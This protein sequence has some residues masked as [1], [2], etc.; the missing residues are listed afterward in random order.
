MGM[1]KWTQILTVDPL[2]VIRGRLARGI[3]SVCISIP[4]IV[5]LQVSNWLKGEV[6][7]E[8]DEKRLKNSRELFY[9]SSRRS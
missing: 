4:C 7:N 8:I 6:I 2:M 1:G 5:L 3:S 9:L